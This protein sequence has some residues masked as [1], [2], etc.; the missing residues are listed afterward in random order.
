MP[1]P[2]PF[3]AAAAAVAECGAAVL[4]FVLVSILR[5]RTPVIPLAACLAFW[6]SVGVIHGALAGWLVLTLAD[7]QPHYIARVIFWAGACLI[8]LPLT[9]YALAQ[10]ADRR[11]LLT[12]LARCVS[13]DAARRRESLNEMDELRSLIVAAMRQDI[14]PVVAEIA[15][16]LKAI[17]PA[18]DATNLAALG[19]QLAGVSDETSR[20]I[21]TTSGPAA[22]PTESTQADAPAPLVA[23]LDF[24]QGRP[25]RAALLTAAALLPVVIALSFGFS[26]VRAQGIG[27]SA[28]VLAV[29][30]VVMAVGMAIPRLPAYRGRRARLSTALAIYCVAGL[31]TAVAA[32]FGPWQ[33]RDHQNLVLALL[34]IVA[35]PFAG[36]AISAAVG[37]GNANLAIVAQLASVTLGTQQ[38]NDYLVQQRGQVRERLAFLTHGPLRGRLSAC[39]MALNFHAEEI[40]TSSAD[41]TQYITSSVLDHLA[42][43]LRE[44]DSL[45]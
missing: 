19:S 32:Y 4:P 35:V 44:L 36:I 11:A 25:T 14:R 38:L 6:A 23:A 37:L 2:T 17:G 41:R 20:I 1:F 27:T 43:A 30:V 28:I 39:A 26:T 15:R 22:I 10:L 16:S 31:S 8:W 7:V 33:P 40:A 9:T 24:E 5:R 34:L 18:L 42:D 3:L 29:A 45:G 12:T 21:A 13:A